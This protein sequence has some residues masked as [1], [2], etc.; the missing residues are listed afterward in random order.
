MKSSDSRDYTKEPPAML[1]IEWVKRMRER[2]EY[3]RKTGVVTW[4]HGQIN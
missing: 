4:F 2:L 1:D 3:Y